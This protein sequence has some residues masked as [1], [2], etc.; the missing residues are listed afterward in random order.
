MVR[1]LCH[2]CNSKNVDTILIVCLVIAAEEKV[3][4]ESFDYIICGGGLAGCLLA[5]RLSADGSKRV[6]V[7]EAGRPD[8]DNFFI[9]IPAGILRLFRSVYD[10]QYESCGDKGCN[11]R[12]I[13]FQR[14]KVSGKC[15]FFSHCCRAS[16][17]NSL[18]PFLFGRFWE[19]LRAQMRC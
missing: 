1:N 8:Y 18:N 16:D 14:G 19:D 17:R 11:G 7:L 4:S 13:F 5:D 2:R 9:R 15:F 10:W 6:L 12:N 3:T